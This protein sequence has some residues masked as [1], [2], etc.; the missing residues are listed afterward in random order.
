M[1]AV[2]AAL[3]GLGGWQV[4]R[5]LP[6]WRT[7]LAASRFA[8]D[9]RMAIAF[10]ARTN[11]PVTLTFRADG[12]AGCGPS[13]EIRGWGEDGI[14]LGRTCLGRDYPGV[15]AAP[16]GG[17]IRC[18][19]EA[20][21]GQDPLPDCSLCAAEASITFRPTGETVGSGASP[22]GDSIVFVPSDGR[23]AA[24]RAVGVRAGVGITR[25]YR[26]DLNGSGWECP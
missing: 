7:A 24:A 17:A 9:V 3:V 11:R 12:E 26:P 14:E 2:V 10:A 20:A 16:V 15:V 4:R 5:L 19:E 25:I 21:A 18:P 23:L 13:W 1:A 6:A 22:A 8:A